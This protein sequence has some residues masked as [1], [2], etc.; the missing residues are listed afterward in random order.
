MQWTVNEIEEST[1][2]R[3]FLQQKN[4]SKHALTEIKFEGGRIE[5][6]G[7]EATVRKILTQGDCVKITFPEEK[8]SNSLIG[9]SI[10]LSIVYEDETVLVVNKPPYMSTIPSR[11]HPSGSLANALIGYYDEQG[12]S[13]SVHI[14]TRLD[15]DTSGLLLVA[16]HSHAHHLLSQ[17]QQKR[18]VK[19]TYY[20][21]VHGMVKPLVGSIDSPIGRKDTSIIEREIRAD[22]QTALTHY[23]VEKYVNDDSL[24]CLRL[25]TGRTHQIRVHMSSIGHPLLGDDLYGGRIDRSLRQ[26]LHCAEL[27]FIHPLTGEALLFKSELPQDMKDLLS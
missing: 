18:E 17:S 1:L 3:S 23:V 21:V 15:R 27:A 11:E 9:E 13:S 20:A 6:N 5:V 14:V 2:L 12:L 22:G 10:P 25:D 24:V 4:I 8:R 16:K 26:A 19:R 7:E